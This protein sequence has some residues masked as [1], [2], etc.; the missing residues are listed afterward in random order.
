[1]SG[2]STRSA[3]SPPPPEP[4]TGDFGSLVT[5]CLRQPEALRRLIGEEA[6]TRTRLLVM[7]L[8]A[9]ALVGLLMATFSGGFQLRAV[10]LKVVAGTLAAMAVCLP[11]LFVF[12]NLAGSGIDFRQALGSMMLAVAVLAMVLL[13]LA[14]VAL[15]F[16]LS[17][18]SSALVGWIHV[19]FL[20]VAAW[21]GGSALKRVWG[22]SAESGSPAGLWMV[23][24]VVVMLQLSTTLRPLLGEYEPLDFA[25][26]KVFVEHWLGGEDD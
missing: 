21:F 1:M 22:P 18:D 16:S 5:T 14:P 8:P 2:D 7:I 24:F 25:E 17:T 19:G 9:M 13:A 10:P 20:L 3:P 26:K 4:P 6:S 23:L 12:S 11:S 15:V